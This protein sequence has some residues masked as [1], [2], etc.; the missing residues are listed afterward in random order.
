M[1]QYF[2][3]LLCV[4]FLISL[5]VANADEPVATDT[6]EWGEIISREDA[7]LFTEFFSIDYQGIKAHLFSVAILSEIINQEDAVGV[8]LYHAIE[9][10]RPTLVIVGV[11]E[12]GNDLRLDKFAEKSRPCPPWCATDVNQ[13]DVSKAG[14]NITREEAELFTDNFTRSIDGIRAHLF[15]A[16]ILTNIINQD[17]ASG[18]RFYYG[19]YNGRITLVAVGVD[20]N[21][22]DIMDGRFAEKSRPCPPWC[23]RDGD[24]F[25]LGQTVR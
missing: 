19:E 13:P 5:P 24:S 11:N 7:E 22:I 25:A 23:A 20:S 21:G 1:R 9:E 16:S 12:S 2:F 17:D 10:G 6:T 8:R 4:V 14:E 3:V 15:S 18:V